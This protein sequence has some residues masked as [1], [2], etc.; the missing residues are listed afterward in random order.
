MLKC[1]RRVPGVASLSI[2]DAVVAGVSG[3][4]FLGTG[5]ATNGDSWSCCHAKSIFWIFVSIIFSQQ[6]TGGGSKLF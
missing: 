5:I 1:L 3:V 2:A 6:S 4:L